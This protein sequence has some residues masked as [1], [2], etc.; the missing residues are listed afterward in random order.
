MNSL[1][2]HEVS[3]NKKY[4]WE[5]HNISRM[6]SGRGSSTRGKD[7]V[8]TMRVFT[9][10]MTHTLMEFCMINYINYL[11]LNRME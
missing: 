6:V 8:T 3:E 4:N 1:H 9:R 7:I 10:G 5:S 11:I 2:N